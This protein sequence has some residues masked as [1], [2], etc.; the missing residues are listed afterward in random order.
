M[1]R[2][3]PHVSPLTSRKQL[4]IAESELNRAQ[5]L[6][7]MAALKMDINRLA[8]RAKSLG[9]I[10]S[11]AGMLMA[12]VTSFQRG[13]LAATETKPSWLQTI[14]KGAGFV[15]NLWLTFRA[16]SHDQKNQPPNPPS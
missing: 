4:L 8:D 11:I 15:S 6:E 3:K 5:L 10:A 2:K 16:K 13:K 12:G 14:L 7:D 1:F 9:S